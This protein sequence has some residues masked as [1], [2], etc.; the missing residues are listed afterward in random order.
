[1][2]VLGAMYGAAWY[3]LL[4]PDV[5]GTVDAEVRNLM[6]KFREAGVPEKDP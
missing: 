4:A 2:A 5:K 6:E 1:M 3:E